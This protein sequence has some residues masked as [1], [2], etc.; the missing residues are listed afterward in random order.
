MNLYLLWT[1]NDDIET[2]IC[3]TFKQTLEKD[4]QREKY[5]KWFVSVLLY[6]IFECVCACVCFSFNFT[7]S[8][9]MCI[10]LRM[11]L[12]L[13]W[14]N[15]TDFIFIKYF[16][17]NVCHFFPLSYALL[18]QIGLSDFIFVFYFILKN[19]NFSF[20]CVEMYV[21]NLKRKREREKTK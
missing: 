1:I 15:K 11:H 20:L 19:K 9:M 8:I 3:I 4:T 18:L 2:I 21:Q 7:I 6:L 14:Q 5:W 13:R 10:H 17:V 16:V 12:H